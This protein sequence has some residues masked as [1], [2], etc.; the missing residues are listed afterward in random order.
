MCKLSND[1]GICTLVA[2]AAA[3]WEVSEGSMNTVNTQILENA[4]TTA[5][6]HQG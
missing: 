5:I 1:P 2:K 4:D 6:I 3:V